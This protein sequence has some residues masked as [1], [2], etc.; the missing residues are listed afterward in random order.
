MAERRCSGV[1]SG[2]A[3]PP[4]EPT[5]VAVTK[6]QGSLV[7]LTQRRSNG[8]MFSTRVRLL[9]MNDQDADR[10]RD[11]RLCAGGSRRR[12]GRGPEYMGAGGAAQRSD[13]R[14]R[15]GRGLDRARDLQHSDAHPGEPDRPGSARPIRVAQG[16][17][18][19]LGAHDHSP[20]RRLRP[21]AACDPLRSRHI[22]G[23][24]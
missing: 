22:S 23:G 17:A 18:R 9:G 12:P 13:L 1:S 19:R 3:V 20:K 7:R 4:S 11:R 6:P 16:L 8:E 24:G 5:L 10:V 14:R 15:L 21:S 2:R